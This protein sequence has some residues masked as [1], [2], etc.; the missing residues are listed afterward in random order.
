[1]NT[2]KLNE[3]IADLQA[4][5]EAYAEKSENNR[6]AFLALSKAFEVSVE[7]CWKAIKRFVME[8]GLD[9]QSPKDAIRDAG[10]LGVIDNVETWLTFINARNAGVHD[11]FSIPQQD[12]VSIASDYLKKAKD[13]SFVD[14]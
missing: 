13:L 8:E 9:P 14:R 4:A 3:S 1:V 6:L 2:T 10:R 12:Y 5:L 7:Y 11:Y